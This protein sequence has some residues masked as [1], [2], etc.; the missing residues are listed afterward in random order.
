[1]ARN[2]GGA[3]GISLTNTLVSRGMQAHQA[4][5]SGHFSPYDLQFQQQFQTMTNMLRQTCDPVTAQNQATGLFCGALQQQAALLAYVDT[6]RLLAI[7]SLF[8]I[9]M[10]FLL[11]KAKSTDG[12]VA[13]H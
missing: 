4:Y 13:M 3:I 7:L 6:F 2:I 1:M 5:L 10:V 8:C 9:P 12:A 11:K